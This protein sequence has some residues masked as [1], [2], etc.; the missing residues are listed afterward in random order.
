MRVGLVLTYAKL[1][2][3]TGGH[4]NA[5]FFWKN[6]AKSFDSYNNIEAFFNLKSSATIYYQIIF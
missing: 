1:P 2:N 3:L 4:T 5:I 6:S